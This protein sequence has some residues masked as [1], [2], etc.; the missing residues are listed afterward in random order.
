M[1]NF[2]ITPLSL[3]LAFILVLVGIFISY[4]E[5][6]STIKEILISV[7]RAVI[8]LVIVGYGLTYLFNLNSE[9]ITIILVMIIGFNAAHHAKKRSQGMPQ[10]FK[11]S[12]IAV[13]SAL[14]LTLTV[15]VLSKSILFIPSQVVPISGMIAGNAM[16]ALGLTYRNLNQLFTDQRQQI[17]EKLALGATIKQASHSIIKQTIKLGMQPTLD[18]AKTIGIVSLPGMMSGLMFAGTVPTIAI[19]Y[20]I[21]VTFM[22]VATTSISTYIAVILAY[23]QAF[24][25]KSQFIYH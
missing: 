4:K 21:M 25:E 7:T 24:N 13:F 18:S 1:S 20:Q 17:Q 16:T 23:K 15:L 11:I 2:N 19:M 14:I 5:K 8:Q 9:I 12:L 3:S 10:A 22:L 6:L